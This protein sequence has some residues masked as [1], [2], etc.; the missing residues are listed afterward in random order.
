[1]NTNTLIEIPERYK[2][3]RMDITN[4]ATSKDNKRI[5]NNDKGI[6]IYFDD[7]DN[8]EPLLFDRDI[9]I[10]D[11]EFNG[12]PFSKYVV[13]IRFCDEASFEIKKLSNYVSVDNTTHPIE[14]INN[15]NII[16]KVIKLIRSF[17]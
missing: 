15:I 3:F 12:T 4:F 14:D 10:L 9:V 11:D 5:E 6:C 8:I 7:T 1:M 16:G 17:D 13:E 2:Q